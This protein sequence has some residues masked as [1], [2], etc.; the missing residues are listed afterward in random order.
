MQAEDGIMK[1]IFFCGV[2]MLLIG[3]ASYAQQEGT[4][5]IGA[6]SLSCGKWLE[7]RNNPRMH[8]QFEQ[9]VLGYMSG[10]NWAAWTKKQKQ[11]DLPDAEA[12]LAFIDQYCRNNPLDPIVAAAAALVQEIGGP[13][14]FHKWKR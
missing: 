2:F 12:A 9:W 11:A 10:I 1:K 6:G 7:A 13:K 14:A 4:V 5:I 8:D 3:S